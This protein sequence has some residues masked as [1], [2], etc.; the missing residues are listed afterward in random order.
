MKKCPMCGSVATDDAAI[1]FECLYSFDLMSCVAMAPVA[2]PDQPEQE[3]EAL[4]GFTPADL[5]GPNPSDYEV[6][7]RDEEMG[8][9][10]FPFGTGSLH[11]GRLPTNDIVLNDKTVSR[12]H[13]HVFFEQGEVWVEDFGSPNPARLNGVALSGKSP[14]KVGDTLQIRGATLELV[15]LV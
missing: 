11:V 9:R 15:K 1:C 7:V 5:G 12:R 6:I 2:A 13:L 14:F 4:V 10:R 3:P 8:T